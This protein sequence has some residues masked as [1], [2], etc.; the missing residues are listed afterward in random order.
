MNRSKLSAAL[1]AALF[2]GTGALASE[3]YIEQAGSGV[4]VNI[5]QTGAGHV[6]GK[7]ANS[8]DPSV[9]EGNSINIDI[10]QD[11]SNNVASIQLINSSDSTD[12]DYISRGDDNLINIGVNGGTGNIIEVTKDGD[13][14]T[15]NVCKT[16][17][18]GNCSAGIE[19][20]DTD[21]TVN[22]A[23]SRN[24]VNM[25][26]ASA[27]SVN[28]INVGQTTISNDNTIN[29]TQTN[30]AINLVNVSVDGDNNTLTIVQQ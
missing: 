14:N 6:V 25:A 11:G 26:L 23:G 9:I 18:S 2:F 20:T 5:T 21:N 13:D 7:A 27:D 22:I 17:L 3:V 12:I 19:V 29:L 15:V 1:L 16:V 24:T 4:T 8:T 10:L 28:V 30:N